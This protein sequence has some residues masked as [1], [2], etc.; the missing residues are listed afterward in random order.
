MQSLQ[1]LVQIFRRFNFQLFMYY[2]KL[3][4]TQFRYGEQFMTVNFPFREM[5]N[6]DTARSKIHTADCKMF[7]FKL[8][9]GHQL[10]E[11]KHFRL[12]QPRFNLIGGA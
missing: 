9:L 4:L 8:K 11:F 1:T 5:L 10:A 7:L 6:E 12:S 2:L 3:T